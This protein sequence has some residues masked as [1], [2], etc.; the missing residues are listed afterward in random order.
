MKLGYLKKKREHSFTM[1]GS[2]HC[3]LQHGDVRYFRSSHSDAAEESPSEQELKRR[4]LAASMEYV[5]LYGWSQKSLQL[6]V[7]KE[8]FPAVAHGLFPKCVKYGQIP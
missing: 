7:E 3:K 1:E 6:G 8:G 5:P 2:Y 4:V